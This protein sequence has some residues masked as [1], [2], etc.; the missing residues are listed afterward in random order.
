LSLRQ[1]K[2]PA[3]SGREPGEDPLHAE[4]NEHD[5][6]NP[7]QQKPTSPI[8]NPGSDPNRKPKTPPSKWLIGL[9]GLVVLAVGTVG[10]NQFRTPGSPGARAQAQSK[11]VSLDAAKTDQEIWRAEAGKKIEALSQE[12]DELRRM[13]DSLRIR[14]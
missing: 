8:L 9:I 14:M 11:P 3:R 1:R 4:T 5:D 7:M 6:M 10:L 2:R 12:K 13:I